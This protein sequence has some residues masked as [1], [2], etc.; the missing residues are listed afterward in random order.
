MQ[1]ADMALRGKADE[2]RPPQQRLP[3]A[4]A[5]LL[6]LAAWRSNLKGLTQKVTK[7]ILGRQGGTMK[8]IKLVVLL[9][10]AI[11]ATI[12]V[13]G[14]N[15]EL[16][17][18]P[19]QVQNISLTVGR[20]TSDYDSLALYVKFQGTG[21]ACIRWHRWTKSY[22]WNSGRGEHWKVNPDID[23]TSS[24]YTSYLKLCVVPAGCAPRKAYVTVWSV[25]YGLNDTTFTL[26][27][28]SDTITGR[29]RP[30]VQ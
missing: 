17:P 24:T 6:L 12:G 18:Q 23:P 21:E 19:L 15:Q 16:E 22:G 29:S 4:R 27:A 2:E 7:R 13:W 5:L 26:L 3:M 8:H 11:V 25:F 14:C 1:R 10:L 20:Q 9:A 30:M 28:T